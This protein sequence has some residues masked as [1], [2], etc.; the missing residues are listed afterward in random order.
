MKQ[1]KFNW[2]SI[3]LGKDQA[4]GETGRVILGDAPLNS[5]DFDEI[6]KVNK[7]IDLFN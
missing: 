1:L 6:C 4:L 2:V 5:A 3:L 7:L